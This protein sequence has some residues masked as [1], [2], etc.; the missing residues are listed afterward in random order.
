MKKLL[1]YVVTYNHEQFIENTINRI[2]KSIFNNYETEIL[3]NDDSSIDKTLDIIKSL[4]Q[5]YNTK[6]KFNI[7]SKNW[8]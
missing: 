1:I 4:K 7:L 2:N 3:I 6:V 5:K 8:I